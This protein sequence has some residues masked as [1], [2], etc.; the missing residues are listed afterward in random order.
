M[1]TH[2][3][4][5]ALGGKIGLRSF[6]YSR[7]TGHF[8]QRLQ[9]DRRFTHLNAQDGSPARSSENSTVVEDNEVGDGGG[10]SDK[11]INSR[12]THSPAY[13]GR[14]YHL[15]H[16]RTRLRQQLWVEDDE[17]GD[18]VG[19]IEKSKNPKAFRAPTLAAY[20][21]R[22]QLD[23]KLTMKSCQSSLRLL[24]EGTTYLEG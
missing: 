3:I 9:Y 15:D 2:G 5:V 16:Q 7:T 24:I 18:G 14:A 20:F 1:Y 10:G 13:S 19:A 11:R 21:P 23:I 8:L 4:H 17:V 6:L 22:K 12:S